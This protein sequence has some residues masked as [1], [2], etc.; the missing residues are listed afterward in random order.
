MGQ[1]RSLLPS[2]YQ[3]LLD[4]IE[5]HLQFVPVKEY[6]DA[7]DLIACFEAA[8]ARLLVFVLC[9]QYLIGIDMELFS[10]G[11][12]MLIHIPDSVDQPVE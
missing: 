12:L 6:A 5:G 4:T 3:E 11:I 10:V 2:E 1:R 9:L 8:I 7:R